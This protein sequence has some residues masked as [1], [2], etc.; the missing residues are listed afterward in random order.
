MQLTNLQKNTFFGYVKCYP[1]SKSQSCTNVSSDKYCSLWLLSPHPRS[2][3]HKDAPYSFIQLCSI[4]LCECVIV[5]LTIVLH[6]G[7]YIASNPIISH[8]IQKENYFSIV[9][10]MLITQISNHLN[11]VIPLSVYFCLLVKTSQREQHQKEKCGPCVSSGKLWPYQHCKGNN[12]LATQRW[13]VRCHLCPCLI[14]EIRGKHH[15]FDCFPM[16]IFL[17][18]LYFDYKGQIEINCDRIQ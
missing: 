9:I 1:C 15:Y 7:I 6:R 17:L 3:I 12:V 13:Q 11:P 18:Y 10:Q 2:S 16:F 4:L 5:Y 8:E 14:K